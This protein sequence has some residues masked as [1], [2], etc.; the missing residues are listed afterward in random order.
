[1]WPFD[2]PKQKS[3]PA[4]RP[5]AYVPDTGRPDVFDPALRH[6]PFAFVKG[7]P[8]DVGAA[9]ALREAR[10]SVLQRCL[11]AL[12]T[13]SVRDAV[14]LRGS[15]TLEDWFPDR[16][17]RAHDV[18]LVVRDVAIAPDTA[19]A[20]AL[21]DEI[22]RAV[23]AVLLA[24]GVE[25][26]EDGISLDSIWTYE[27]AE[28]RRLSVPWRLSGSPGDTLQIDVVFREPLQV[29]PTLEVLREA[30][31]AATY[32]AESRGPSLWFASRVESLAWKLMWL[33]SDMSPQAK[34]LY[35]AVLLAENVRLPVELLE[36]VCAGKGEAWSHGSDARFLRDLEIEWG[37]FAAE[38]PELA[39]GDRADWLGRLASTLQLVP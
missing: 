29:A 32:R 26:V 11:R 28:G 8:A 17:R 27:R 1:M 10:S 39:V 25:V 6:Y 18:D 35:D 4:T 36:R 9:S 12:A 5:L 20:T 14:V 7:P 22:R 19:P 24:G 15:L 33:E 37:S 3:R 31:G 30:G 2:P 13:S 23:R 34:D 21:L 38:Y 16:A